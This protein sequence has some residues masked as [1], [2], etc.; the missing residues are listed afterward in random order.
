MAGFSAQG[1]P[2]AENRMLAKSVVLT[3]ASN[4]LVVS[5]I[6]ILAIYCK[7]EVPVFLLVS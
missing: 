4:S 2:W 6:H 1:Y 3:W 7:T 5:R